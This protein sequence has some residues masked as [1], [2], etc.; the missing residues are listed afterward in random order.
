M[1]LTMLVLF[2]FLLSTFSSS[3]SQDFSHCREVLFD[4]GIILGKENV[5]FLKNSFP[6]IEYAWDDSEFL[7]YIKRFAQVLKQQGTNLVIVPIPPKPVVLSAYLDLVDQHKPQYDYEVSK[8]AYYSFVEQLNQ[9]GILTV[10]VLTPIQEFDWSKSEVLPNYKNDHHWTQEAARLSAGAVAE[11][12]QKLLPYINLPKIQVNLTFEE[13]SRTRVIPLAEQVHKICGVQPSLE[14]LRNYQI[15]FEKSQVNSLFGESG[16]NFVEVGSS[17]SNPIHGF[18]AFLSE[19]LKSEVLN[20][21]TA[22]GRTFGALEEYFIYE[23]YKNDK[24]KFLIWE[25]PFIYFAQMDSNKLISRLRQIIPS[26]HGS[27]DGNNSFANST[28]NLSEAIPITI[29][30]NID[31]FSIKGN[32]YYLNLFFSDLSIKRFNV[33]IKYRDGQLDNLSIKRSDRVKNNG[34]F[35]LEFLDDVESN[36]QGISL[37]FPEN[38]SG[39]LEVY[40]CKIFKV[41]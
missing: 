23:S 6:K 8:Q 24:P 9:Q 20:L 37:I 39:N 12:I 29:F 41:Y 3:L 40:I 7:V 13:T 18:T 10:D 17:Y 16:I 32:G 5:F 15:T 33:A 38:P 19:V 22:G 14:N 1:K 31:K 35:F 30:E 25:F 36:V 34:K 28:I 11:V 27:C 26:A 21:Y 4:N 2:T